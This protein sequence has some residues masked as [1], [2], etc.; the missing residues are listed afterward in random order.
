MRAW[1]SHH[2]ISVYREG[3]REERNELTQTEVAAKLNISARTMNRLIK[4][5]VIPAR[6]ACKGAPWVIS[7]DALELPGI[8]L[9]LKK[10]ASPSASDGEQKIFCFQQR[11][12][13]S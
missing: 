8:A 4:R 13:V 11:R 10:G 5:G 7:A 1:R 12:E 2:G 3:E 9:A 6:Q